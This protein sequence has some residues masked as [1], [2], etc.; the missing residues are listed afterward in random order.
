MRPTLTALL[1]TATFTLPALAQTPTVP[2][3]D[4]EVRKVDL[5]AKKIT[6]RHGDIQHLDMPPMT[7]VFQVAN[8]AELAAIQPG[9]RVR[10]KAARSQGGAYM[11]SD[12]QPLQK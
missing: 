2:L 11:A 5:S 9:D 10:F 6:I 8:P 3:S 7:M 1:V 4:G 12:I